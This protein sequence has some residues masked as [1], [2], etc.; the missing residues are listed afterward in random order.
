MRGAAVALLVV[1]LVAGCSPAGSTPS[2]TAPPAA[3]ASIA[4]P[5]VS[6]LSPTQA[7][8]P[9]QSPK[10]GITATPSP[11]PGSTTASPA[12]GP[13]HIYWANRVT[14]DPT[15][16]QTTMGRANLDGSGVN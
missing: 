6:I 7:S 16:G 3:S 11:T 12:A 2:A 5:T 10:P 8:T 13:G 4:T 1:G 9:T 15:D 14:V